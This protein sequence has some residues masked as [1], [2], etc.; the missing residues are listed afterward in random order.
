[1]HRDY[2]R[3]LPLL[4]VYGSELNQ[5]WTNLID[6]AID[7]MSGNGDIVVK[8]YREMDEAVVEITDNGSGTLT[9]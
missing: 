5:V 4:T 6:N 2:D 9:M 3:S 1:M 8:T 7:A